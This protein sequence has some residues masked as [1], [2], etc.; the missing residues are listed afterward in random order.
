MGDIYSLVKD[1]DVVETGELLCSVACRLL[2]LD[3][4]GEQVLE[5]LSGVEEDLSESEAA[6]V[7]EHSQGLGTTRELLVMQLVLLLGVEERY[8]EVSQVLAKEKNCSA[9]MAWLVVRR[10]LVPLLVTSPIYPAL[11]A[12]CLEAGGEQV[13]S[14][15]RQLR[16]AGHRPLAASI[17]MQSE[18]VPAGLRTLT[19][20]AM[21]WLAE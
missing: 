13:M 3:R 8:Q 10:G 16:E 17:Q 9:M 20:L 5:L 12:V 6:R 19:S 2:D 15:V 1:W 4:E 14:I 11:V 21:R 7:L 18:G